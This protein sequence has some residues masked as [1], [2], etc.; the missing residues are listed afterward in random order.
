MLIK[1]KM[2]NVS[3]FPVKSTDN[4]S[5]TVKRKKKQLEIFCCID[6]V[7]ENIGM[8]YFFRNFYTNKKNNV[9]IIFH[10]C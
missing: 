10:I 4:K 7:L 3:Y 5:L 6:Y 1:I 8:K 2:Y 9:Y